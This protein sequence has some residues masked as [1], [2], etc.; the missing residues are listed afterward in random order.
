VRVEI[1]VE[2]TRDP[3]RVHAYRALPLVV[4]KPYQ[5]PRA[6]RPEAMF[7]VSYSGFRRRMLEDR[8]TRV[9]VAGFTV[10]PRSENN[11]WL[12]EHRS[13]VR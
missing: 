13:D 6:A 10:I 7:A 12:H 3:T 11:L 9:F 1:D 8:P 4:L 2:Q 5:S